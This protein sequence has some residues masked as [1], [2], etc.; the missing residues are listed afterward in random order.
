MTYVI[1]VTAG[2]SLASLGV[3]CYLAYALLTEEK[4][5]A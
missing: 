4:P 2:A 3:I 1:L 5:D